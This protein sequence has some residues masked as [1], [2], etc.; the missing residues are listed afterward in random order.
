MAT[1]SNP[2]RTGFAM[3]PMQMSYTRWPGLLVVD[4]V[5]AM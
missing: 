5:L 3:S 1:T 4:T 2:T